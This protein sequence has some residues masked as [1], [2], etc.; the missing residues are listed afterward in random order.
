VE[1]LVDL[2]EGIGPVVVL[3]IIRGLNGLIRLIGIR[4]RLIVDQKKGI[5][6]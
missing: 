5:Y 1:V 3:A 6:W 2:A 4:F